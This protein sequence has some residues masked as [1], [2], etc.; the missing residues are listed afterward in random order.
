M[1]V[2][3][4]SRIVLAEKVDKVILTEAEA[5]L[6]QKQAVSQLIT[7]AQARDNAALVAQAQARPQAPPANAYNDI[8]QQLRDMQFQQAMQQQQQEEWQQWQ[9]Q[10]QQMQ[11]QQQQWMQ[12][13]PRY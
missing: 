12:Q 10:G 13:Q 8:S 9:Q 6:L 11:Q 5:D 4:A 1:N 2:A 3:E 7:E